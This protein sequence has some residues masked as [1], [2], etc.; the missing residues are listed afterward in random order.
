M[1][2]NRLVVDL[3]EKKVDGVFAELDQGHLPGAAAGIAIA[4]MPVYRKGFGLAS[5]DLPIVLSPTIR[6]RIY[7]T[8][9]HFTMSRLHIVVRGGQGRHRRSHREISARTVPRGA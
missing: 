9:K 5:M 6:M 1:P 3:D 4:G 8:S 7:S 2:D